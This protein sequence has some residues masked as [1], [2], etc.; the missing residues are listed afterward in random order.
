MG[1]VVGGAGLVA[2][3]GVNPRRCIPARLP[4]PCRGHLL[5][6]QC[7]L[8]PNYGKG[9]CCEHLPAPFAWPLTVISV[10]GGG[11]RGTS[12]RVTGFPGY[13]PPTAGGTADTVGIRGRL[14]RQGAG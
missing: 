2:I 11:T 5:G 6:E 9:S 8:L 4:S 10:Y 3:L 7:G 14:A 13:V 12:L 1:S